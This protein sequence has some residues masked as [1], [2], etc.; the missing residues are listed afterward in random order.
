MQLIFIIIMTFIAIA[1][2]EVPK[3]SEKKYKR[4]LVVFWCLY[5]FGFVL[6]LLYNYGVKIPSPLKGIQFLI[7]E[8]LHIGYK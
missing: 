6:V 4:E 3:L 1:L 5:I 2:Y 7:N 8:V